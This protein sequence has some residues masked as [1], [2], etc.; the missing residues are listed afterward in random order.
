MEIK[1]GRKD[2]VLTEVRRRPD[3]LEY[4]SHHPYLAYGLLDNLSIKF[5]PLTSQGR[6]GVPHG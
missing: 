2:V 4:F 3:A 5:I 6:R 1:E